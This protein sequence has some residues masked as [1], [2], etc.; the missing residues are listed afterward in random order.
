MQSWAITHFLHLKKNNFT[1]TLSNRANERKCVKKVWIFESHFFCSLKRA[2]AQFQKGNFPTLPLEQFAHSKIYTFFTHFFTFAPFKS[3]I[4]WLHFLSLIKSEIVRLH[5][6]VALLKS[7][8]VGSHFVVT[9][10]K[11][12]LCNYTFWSLLSK[13]QLCNCTFLH[14]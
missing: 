11:V 5:F 9:L 7:A 6:L 13:V 8:I 14:F 2:I 1:I 12:G 4:V 3:A 10:L